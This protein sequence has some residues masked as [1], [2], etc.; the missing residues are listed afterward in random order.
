MTA[1]DNL[2]RPSIPLAIESVKTVWEHIP[3]K[4]VCKSFLKCGISNNID[5]TEDDDQFEDFFQEGVAKTWDVADNDSYVDYY[6][7]SPAIHGI[8]DYDWASLFVDDKNVFEG[9]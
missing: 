3:K 4:M 8:L 9:C 2:K 1:A 5:T 7:G 6:D